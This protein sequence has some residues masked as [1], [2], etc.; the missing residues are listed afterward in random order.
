MYIY[1]VK[2][3]NRC[4]LYASSQGA[5]R[6]VSQCHKCSS[7][8][9][10]PSPL[11]PACILLPHPAFIHCFAFPPLYV[12]CLQ[13]AHLE[14]LLLI[15]YNHYYDFNVVYL[16]TYQVCREYSVKKTSTIYY[17]LLSKSDSQIHFTPFL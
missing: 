10:A 4:F 12:F 15:I 7:Q 17:E 8:M 6:S 14:R 1:P 11:P 3:K 9:A 16:C 2:M 5:Q 13:K